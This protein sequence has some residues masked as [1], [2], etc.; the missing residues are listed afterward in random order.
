MS[1]AGLAFELRHFV[2]RAGLD[3]PALVPR[4]PWSAVECLRE[5]DFGL[6]VQLVGVVVREREDSLLALDGQMLE[7]AVVLGT[8]HGVPFE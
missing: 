8:F 5:D 3:D 6:R 4:A 7:I 1:L 2:S